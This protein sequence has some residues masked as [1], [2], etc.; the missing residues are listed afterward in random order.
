MLN[1][2]DLIPQSCRPVNSKPWTNPTA[3]FR[4]NCE[5]PY[6]SH[7]LTEAVGWTV[8]RIYICS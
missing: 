5:F 6:K 1:G 3:L 8:F 2:Q 7:S 4:Y